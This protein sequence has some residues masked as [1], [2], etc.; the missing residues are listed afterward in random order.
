VGGSGGP[1]GWTEN[2]PNGL[3]RVPP[4]TQLWRGREL[5]GFFAIRDLRVR[6]KQAV[7]GVLWVVLQ[8]IAAVAAFTL[9]FGKL[10]GV[11]SQGIPY[12]LFA[13]AGLVTWSYFSGV[14]TGASEVLVGNAALITKV[15]FPRLTAPAGSVLT[16][17]VDLGVSLLLVLALCLAYREAPTW[18]LTALPLWLLLLTVAAFGVGVW[19]SALNVRFRDVRHA[20]HP[21]LQVWLFLSPV[22]YPS[23]LIGGPAR[24]AYAL[25]PMVGIIGLGRWSLLGAPWPGWPLAVSVA[26]AGGVLASGCWYFQ[27][28]E[29]SFADVI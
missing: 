7:L 16:P 1:A 4:W 24:L 18:A 2:G 14:V 5:I 10:A 9:V 15:Y 27:R 20:A 3:G 26:T 17:L 13:L 29:R 28:A 21:M 19:F 23:T 6:Y 12:P 25:N 22:A 8:P 11:S